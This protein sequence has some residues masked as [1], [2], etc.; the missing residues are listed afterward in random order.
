MILDQITLAGR[1]AYLRASDDDA[2]NVAAYAPQ[3]VAGGG[4]VR[5]GRSF[6]IGD[7]MLVQ[8]SAIQLY[9]EHDP[10]TGRLARDPLPWITLH[11]EKEMFPGL[12]A[13][14]YACRTHRI[15]GFEDLSRGTSSNLRVMEVEGVA[16]LVSTGDGA[17]SGW[18]SPIYAMPD[19]LPLRAAAWEIPTHKTTPADS[20]V[21]D[22][23]LFTW[24]GDP[25]SSDPQITQLTH[26][27]TPQS[28]RYFALDPVIDARHYQISFKAAVGRDAPLRE[29]HMG[30]VTKESLGRPLLTGI[31]LLEVVPSI[32][33]L[34]SVSELLAQAGDH[35]LIGAAGEP[36]RRL[37]ATVMLGATLTQGESIVVDLHGADPGVTVLEA[38]M[39]GTVVVRP[40]RT[41]LGR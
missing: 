24:I 28:P 8:V 23:A 34:H 27:A 17:S 33:Q 25:A 29:R 5:R 6:A 2:V 12:F 14:P 20:F 38:R 21:Y 11:V 31:S 19:A 26:H 1:R 4:V 39:L 37:L 7:G 15:G 36:P 9:L 16:T 32:Y 40:P 3:A 41:E 18:R 30:E 13:D 10:L 22:L 35:E